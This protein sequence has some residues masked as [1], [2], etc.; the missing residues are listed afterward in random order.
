MARST[1]TGDDHTTVTARREGEDERS[2]HAD[3]DDGAADTS[4]A[5]DDADPAALAAAAAAHGELWARLVDLVRELRALA[6][7][8]PPAGAGAAGARADAERRCAAA[9]RSFHNLQ[10]RAERVA[11]RQQQRTAAAAVGEED[12]A[13]AAAPPCEFDLPLGLFLARLDSEEDGDSPTRPTPSGA[14]ATEEAA[15]A[16]APPSSPQQMTAAAAMRERA[17][18]AAAEAEEERRKRSA[19]KNV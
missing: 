12:G 16:P 3:G 14:A 17:A 18:S 4:D 7:D 1:G 19:G 9:A 6:A 2:P 13:D 8:T 15:A 11:L 10:A 5:A